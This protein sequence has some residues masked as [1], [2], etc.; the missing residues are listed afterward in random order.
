M[1][2]FVLFGRQTCVACILFG[3]RQ[4]FNKLEYLHLRKDMDSKTMF[5]LGL[6]LTSAVG[7][8]HTLTLGR[9]TDPGRIEILMLDI[10][11]NDELFEMFK[12]EYGE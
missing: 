7:C 10:Y 4:H 9:L 12:S 3:Q 5:A 11:S 6:I 8:V 2:I 1:S